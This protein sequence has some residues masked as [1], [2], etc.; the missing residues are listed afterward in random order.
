MIALLGV[1]VRNAILYVDYA[2]AISGGRGF[3]VDVLRAAARERVVPVLMTALTSG[4][5]VLPLALSGHEPG[6]EILYPVATVILGGLV[7]N[8]LLDFL[9]TPGLLADQTDPTDD[10]PVPVGA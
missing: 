7:T 9:V 2:A 6:R 1:A 3:S 5:G 4:I 10:P 8:T